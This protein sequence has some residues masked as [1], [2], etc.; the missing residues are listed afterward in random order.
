MVDL[1]PGGKVGFQGQS[2]LRKG[3]TPN[4][5]NRISNR[6]DGPS[7]QKQLTRKT[8]LR[9]DCRRVWEKES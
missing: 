2:S 7:L 9:S 4:R 6:I 5:K 3:A 8:E 1:G